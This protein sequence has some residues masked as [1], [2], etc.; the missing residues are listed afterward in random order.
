MNK[1][2][3][4]IELSSK[5]EF[6]CIL[7]FREIEYLSLVALGYHNSQIASILGISYYTVKKTLE[8]IFRKLKAKDRANAIA[9]AFIHQILCNN[10][11]KN[12]AKKYSL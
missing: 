4:K 1:E 9:I 2:A 8:V 12:T 7:T 5:Q 10:I 3:D 6:K 11:L